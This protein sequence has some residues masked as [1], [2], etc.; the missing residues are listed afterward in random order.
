MGLSR[1][2]LSIRSKGRLKNNDFL[3]EFDDDVIDKQFVRTRR[4]ELDA[5]PLGYRQ[6][7]TLGIHNAQAD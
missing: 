3:G 6:R 5:V 7:K 1:D 4:V 2:A